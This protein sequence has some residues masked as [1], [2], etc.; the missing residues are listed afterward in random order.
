MSLSGNMEVFFGEKLNGYGQSEV[1]K[2]SFR[3]KSLQIE[4]I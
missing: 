2:W 3:P 4:L 1:G